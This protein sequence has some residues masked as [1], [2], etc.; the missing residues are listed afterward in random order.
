MGFTWKNAGH[1]F[2]SLFKEVVVVAKKVGGALQN[3]KN[4]APVIEALTS[5]VSPQAAAVEQI[6]FGA[7][8]SVISVVHSV[9]DAA[10]ANGVDVRFDAEVVA[11]IKMLIKNFP[12]IVAQ[13]E[14]QFGK[15]VA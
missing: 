3:V 13:V 6:A 1:A 12:E 8:G 10:T 14:A 9:E 15:K 11:E 4:E 2:A 5:L 7:L